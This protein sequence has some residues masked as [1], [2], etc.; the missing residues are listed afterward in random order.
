MVLIQA[1]ASL[2][3]IFTHA[4]IKNK[5]LSE[6]RTLPEGADI[7]QLIK[8]P[9]LTA[10]CRESLRI[11]PI[12]PI[13]LRTLNQPFEYRGQALNPGDTIGLSLTLLHSNET[14]WQEP[15][16]F[17]PERFLNQHYTQYE[18]APFGGGARRCLGAAFAL[19]EMKILLAT[20]LLNINLEIKPPKNTLPHLYGMI[21]KPRKIFWGTVNKN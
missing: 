21:M 6:L 12:V 17:N 20:I 16:L 3:Y 10:V 9:Y 14:R 1:T 5:L 7:D 8:L 11:H 13:V 19:Y 4:E 15:H 2:Y 18:F